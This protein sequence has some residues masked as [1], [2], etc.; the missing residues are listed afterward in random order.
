[1]PLYLVNCSAFY[2]GKERSSVDFIGV[3]SHR[4]NA[5]SHGWTA[6]YELFP[7]KEWHNY[8]EHRVTVHHVS[9]AIV[10]KAYN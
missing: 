7:P 4:G 8:T 5:L 9:R 10:E 6:C 2:F 1:M 3:A